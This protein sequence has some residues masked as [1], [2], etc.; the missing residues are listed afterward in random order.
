MA[1]LAD[2]NL[3]TTRRRKGCAR[4]WERYCCTVLQY[5]PLVFVYGLTSW[6]IWVAVNVG[7]LP[8]WR[9]PAVGTFECN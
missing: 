8:G 6:A 5:F 4:A 1:T 2:P 9:W 7:F 3:P